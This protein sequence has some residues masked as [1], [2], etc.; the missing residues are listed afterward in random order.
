MKLYDSPT[1][2]VNAVSEIV[3]EFR[4]MMRSNPP[5]TIELEVRLGVIGKDGHFKT[6]V[7]RETIDAAV[8][9][10]SSN[11]TAETIDWHE[12][13][14]FFW[15][16]E[17]GETVRSR[18]SY[19]TDSLKIGVESVTKTRISQVTMRHGDMAIRVSL[20]KEAPHLV[21][22]PTCS[23]DSVR[24]QQ[25]KTFWWGRDDPRTWRYDFSLTWKG[26]T[27]SAAEHERWHSDPQY[28]VE[29]ELIA[30]SYLATRS[31]EFVAHSLLMKAADLCPLGSRSIDLDSVDFC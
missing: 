5:D 10:L 8:H 14:D 17:S 28:E 15:T 26:D 7:P 3:K 21:T 12:Q 31:N 19:D 4:D 13:Q 1:L 25:R 29:V 27:K 30:K 6:A 9:M 18:S 22:A 11:P 2:A 23:T 24:I 20:S 16:N